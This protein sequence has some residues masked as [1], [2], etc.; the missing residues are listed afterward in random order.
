[1]IACT[2][3]GHSTA[4]LELGGTRVV[5]D[6]LLAG[7]LL[8]LVRYA[9]TPGPEALRADLVLVSH[10]H[11]DHCHLPSLARYAPDVPIIVPRGAE[12]LLAELAG[13]RLLPVVPGDSV[14]VAGV[15]VDVL[16]ASHDGRRHPL[17]RSDPPALGFRLANDAGSC[18]YPGDTE[19]R[20]DLADVDPVDLALV[21]VGG[22]GPTLGTGHLEPDQAAEAVRRVGARWAVPVH[23]G[24][25]WPVGLQHLARANHERLFVTPGRRFAAALAGSA[26]EAV[27]LASG[28]RAERP[29][30]M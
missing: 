5:T 30:S 4:T 23:W 10:L 11:Q 22:W 13:D 1:V 15:R 25:F 17:S 12:R 29:H 20:D 21:P 27:V 6:P 18:W 28:E 7:R 2:W 3:W 8:H 9:E 16:L 24:T 14:V 26:T 19:L